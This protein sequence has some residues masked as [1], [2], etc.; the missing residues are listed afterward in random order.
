M[1]S[2]ISKPNRTGWITSSMRSAG[3]CGPT[4]HRLQSERP[5]YSQA[6]HPYRREARISTGRRSTAYDA[7]WQKRCDSLGRCMCQPRVE[8]T[9]RP[10]LSERWPSGAIGRAGRILVVGS[11]RS[12]LP[13]CG[14]RSPWV[15]PTAPLLGPCMFRGRV[16]VVRV[17]LKPGPAGQGSRPRRFIPRGEPRPCTLV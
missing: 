8:V 12:G 10:V 14:V 2:R 15:A 7:S 1:S 5:A 11:P 16:R 13:D 4:S 17:V 6:L 3:E 9:A